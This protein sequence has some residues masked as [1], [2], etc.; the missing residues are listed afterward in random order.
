MGV[1]PARIE[2]PRKGTSE[3]KNPAPEKGMLTV[4][5]LAH[6]MGISTTWIYRKCKAGI[7]PHLRIGG[8]VRFMEKDLEA[9]MAGHKVKGCL[10]V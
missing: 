9:W 4:E 8:V 3:K 10:K 5:G 1:I 2:A 7:L 6:K